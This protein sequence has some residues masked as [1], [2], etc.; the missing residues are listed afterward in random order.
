MDKSRVKIPC[1]VTSMEEHDDHVVLHT[2]E[3]GTIAADIVVGADGIRSIVRSHI[4]SMQPKKQTSDDCRSFT[5]FPRN[6]C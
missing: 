5:T 6:L 4:D 1:M 3:Q 2:R